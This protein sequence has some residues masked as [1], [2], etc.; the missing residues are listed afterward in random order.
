MT[1]RLEDWELDMLL[2]GDGTP[3][4]K[5]IL[6]SSPA[7]KTRF[8]QLHREETSFIEALF[9][10]ECPPSL[11][12]GDLHLGLLDQSTA[13]MMQQHLDLCEHCSEEFVAITTLLDE[14]LFQGASARTFRKE[15]SVGFLKRIV[16][17]LEQAF[18]ALGTLEPE[19]RGENKWKNAYYSGGD[20]LLSLTRQEREQGHAL[21][22]S[23][24]ADSIS[25][26]ATLTQ[27][28]GLIYETHIAAGGTFA[29]NDVTAG[30]Y[31]LVI[32][33]PEAE[34]VVPSLAWPG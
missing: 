11:T 12:L 27:Q 30:D 4:M 3:E 5:A 32:T 13:Q 22:G 10:P 29:F 7:N 15:S 2:G 34:L 1:R 28:S 24:L 19:L 20:Y 31:E 8:A 33:T 18:G 21:V 9:R 26:Q 23:I 17:S 16:M 25:G 6:A 14:R